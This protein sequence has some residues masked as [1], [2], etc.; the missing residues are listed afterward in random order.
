[1]DPSNLISPL[2]SQT[3]KQDLD[4]SPDKQSEELTE[5][6]IKALKMKN[7]SALPLKTVK[8]AYIRDG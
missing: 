3:E 4:S 7:A 2:L 6:R 1:M 5:M 8:R